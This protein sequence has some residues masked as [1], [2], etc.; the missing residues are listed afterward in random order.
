MKKSRR[1]RRME[2]H[3]R[4]NKTQSSLNLVSLMDIFTILVFFLLVNSSDTQQ[5]PNAK[6]ISLPTSTA[7]SF[8]KENLTIMISRKDIIIQGRK[9]TT[10]SRILKDENRISN[11]LQK[12]LEYRAKKQGRLSKTEKALGRPITIM[13]D[14][15]I[16]YELLKKIMITCSESGFPRISLAVIRKNEDKPS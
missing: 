14:R 16:P 3:H 5:L 11:E 15:S 6:T 8:P 10:V 2:R 12:E 13:G 1:T 9:I 4:R 7:D